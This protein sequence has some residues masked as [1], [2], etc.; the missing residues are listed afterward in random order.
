MTSVPLRRKLVGNTP[1]VWAAGALEV[2]ADLQE[3]LDDREATLRQQVDHHWDVVAQE[4]FAVVASFRIGT[5]VLARAAT[6][7]ASL[8]LQWDM[9]VRSKCSLAF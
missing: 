2:E 7:P 3:L 9:R 6:L 5:G 1:R 8:S 4:D